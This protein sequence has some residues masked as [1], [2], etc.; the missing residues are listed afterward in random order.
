MLQPYSSVHPIKADSAAMAT[1]QGQL[2]GREAELAAVSE[3]LCVAEV[4]RNEARKTA[5]EAA[6]KTQGLTERV[7]SFEEVSL[8]GGA[9]ILSIMIL[10]GRDFDQT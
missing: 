1:L 8:P 10:I 4:E 6:A 3:K 5:Q 2:K 7:T 9:F